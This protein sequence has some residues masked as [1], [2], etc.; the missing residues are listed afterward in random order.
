MTF[1]RNVA[2]AIILLA[3]STAGASALSFKDIAGKWCGDATDYTFSRD[4]LVVIFNDGSATKKFKVTSYEYLDGIVKMHW[5]N[6]DDES[7]T[8]FGEFSD[9]GT[10][11]QL[12]N[13]IG[14]RRPFHRC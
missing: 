6:K 11:A 1:I 9:D 5:L 3:G 14:P 13:K 12:K 7:F 8:D 2:L 10:M 4:T